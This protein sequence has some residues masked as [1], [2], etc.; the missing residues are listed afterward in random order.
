VFEQM[1]GT[2]AFSPWPVG[3]SDA[4]KTAHPE[5][6][7]A[8]V[9]HIEAGY[10]NNDTLFTR[11]LN[12]FLRSHYSTVV[13]YWVLFVV[14]IGAVIAGIV[15][16]LVTGKPVVGLAFAGLGVVA[17]LTYFVSFP[18]QALEE[19]LLFI[20]WLGVIYNSYWKDLALSFNRDTAQAELDKATEDAI[21]Q[22]KELIASYDKAVKQRPRPLARSGAKA[23]ADADKEI[24]EQQ[25][26]AG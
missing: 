3:P 12:A 1:V 10:R 17:F 4:D 20:T 21:R 14:G 5:L 18:T 25:A 2:P 6:Y 11:I 15:I 23:V 9:G 13:M 19:N 26:Q 16:A 22:L 8:W 24:E 7:A